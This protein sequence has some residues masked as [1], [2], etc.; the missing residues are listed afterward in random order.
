M[1]MNGD[2]KIDLFG[3]V[4][5]GSSDGEF[6]VWQNNWNASKP[7]TMFDL[8]VEYV[9]MYI[10][11]LIHANFCFRIDPNFNG[12]Q[13]KLS[14][15]HSNA[16]VDLNGDCLAGMSRNRPIGLYSFLSRSFPD[17]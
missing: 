5:G 17:L 16:A 10:A 12:A 7:S 14:N 4:P 9:S 6:K 11:P 13:C 15:P 1:D 8:Y 3:S 2:L